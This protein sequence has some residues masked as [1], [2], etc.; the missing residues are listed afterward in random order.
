MQAIYRR[1]YTKFTKP[2]TKIPKPN[3]TFDSEYAMTWAGRMAFMISGYKPSHLQEHDGKGQQGLDGQL[4]DHVAAPPDARQEARLGLQRAHRAAGQHAA[5][6]SRCGG[7]DDDDDSATNL[8]HAAEEDPD[9]GEFVR[10]IV[11]LM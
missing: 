9:Q 4:L 3:D 2:N 11:N 1:E 10:F 7:G 6:D 5:H 8:L